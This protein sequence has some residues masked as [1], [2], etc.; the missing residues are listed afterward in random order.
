[1][2]AAEPTHTQ[3]TSPLPSA[4]A[5][6]LPVPRGVALLHL[7]ICQCRFPIREDSSVPGGYRF[8]A[9][10]T[11]ADRVYC[12]RHQNIAIASA[13]SRTGK[14]FFGSHKRKSVA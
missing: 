14:T 11:S 2:A 4:A 3:I 12:N 7:R 1:M 5:R 10:A 6:P 9:E 8:C 13:K